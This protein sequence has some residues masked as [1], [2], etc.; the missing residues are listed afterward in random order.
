M[1]AVAGADAVGAFDGRG[2]PLLAACDWYCRY[3][4]GST[5]G[6]IGALVDSGE[7]A[8]DTACM[9]KGGP[10]S[11]SVRSSEGGGSG[12]AAEEAAPSRG[13]PQNLQNVAPASQAP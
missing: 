3:R 2:T 7:R 4:F 5:G 11:T 1:R 10:E 6:V 8:F 9:A 12:A 13:A